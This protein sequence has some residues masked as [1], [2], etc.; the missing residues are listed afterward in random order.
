M[1]P[2]QKAA[3][4]G[5]LAQQAGCN[6]KQQLARPQAQFCMCATLAS[7]PASFNHDD[8]GSE[9]RVVV[10]GETTSAAGHSAFKPAH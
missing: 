2:G 9:L 3:K 1:L 6:G 5:C 4:A 8:A 7:L 10:W